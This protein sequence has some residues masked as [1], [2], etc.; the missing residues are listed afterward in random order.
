MLPQNQSEELINYKAPL[1]RVLHGQE[2]SLICMV[3]RANLGGFWQ[4]CTQKFPDQMPSHRP[5]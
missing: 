4:S 2:N 1:T 3:M 5:K